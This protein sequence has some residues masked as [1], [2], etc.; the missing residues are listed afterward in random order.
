[1]RQAAAECMHVYVLGCACACA[2][3]T[4]G[5]IKLNCTCRN[6]WERRIKKEIMKK[7]KKKQQPHKAE[8]ATEKTEQLF[9]STCIS[10]KF[11]SG[12]V[13]DD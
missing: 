5:G 1:M 7:K 3:E 8:V 12:V 6:E 11:D 2:K 10:T 9:Q 13:G 4:D